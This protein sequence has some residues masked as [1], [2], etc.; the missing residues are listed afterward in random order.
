M[1]NLNVDLDFED[2]FNIEKDNFKNFNVI[3]DIQIVSVRSKVT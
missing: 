3:E 2:R 1:K